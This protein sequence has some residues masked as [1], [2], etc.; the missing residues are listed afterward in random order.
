MYS[1]AGYG[2]SRTAGSTCMLIQRAAGFLSVAVNR[3]DLKGRVLP[4][5]KHNL[6]TIVSS[7]DALVKLRG[8][9]SFSKHNVIGDKIYRSSHFTVKSM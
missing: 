6:K 9:S 7:W 5:A 1:S 4:S 2:F 3:W 8:F